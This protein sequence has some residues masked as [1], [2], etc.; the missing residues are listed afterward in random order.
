MQFHAIFSKSYLKSTF[1]ALSKWY[2]IWS[3]KL[4]LFNL[5]PALKSDSSYSSPILRKKLGLVIFLKFVF[6][7]FRAYSPV[8]TGLYCSMGYASY[9]VYR[10]GVGESRKLALSLYAG[11]L[12]LNWS[13]FPIFF[14]F[15]KLDLVISFNCVY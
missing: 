12:L 6:S 8:L 7:Q 14:R 15:K 13:Y 9:L 2:Q 4:I 3:T 11:Q 5:K 10:D 1:W